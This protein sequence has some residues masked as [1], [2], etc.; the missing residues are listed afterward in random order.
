MM[1]T[2]EFVEDWDSRREVDERVEFCPSCLRRGEPP[3]AGA[4]GRG[5]KE[6]S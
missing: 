4:A 6:E 2:V 3:V 5:T 1:G